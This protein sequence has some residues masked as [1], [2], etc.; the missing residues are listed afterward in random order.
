[1]AAVRMRSVV[2]NGYVLGAAVLAS[3]GGFSM[4]YDMGVISLINNMEQFH[5]RYPFAKT[6]FGEEFMTAMLL[7][8]AFVGCIFMPL[9]PTDIL[10]MGDHSMR[11]DFRH[12]C[13][14]FKPQHQTMRL[15]SW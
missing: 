4:G 6:S 3:L 7:L 12:R 10:E 13:Y 5:A 1:M 8:G 2:S 9:W 15:G 11:G 14:S